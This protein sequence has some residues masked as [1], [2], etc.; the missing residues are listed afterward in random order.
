M[1]NEL[2][3][4]WYTVDRLRISLGNLQKISVI[5]VTCGKFSKKGKKL[6]LTFRQYSK[7]CW[8]FLESGWKYSENRRQTLVILKFSSLS[9]MA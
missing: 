5:L 7:N 9:G 1:M 3:I 4:C 8:K 2:K 6:Q